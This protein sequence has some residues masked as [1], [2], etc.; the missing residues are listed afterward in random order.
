MNTTDR[1]EEYISAHIDPEDPLLYEMTR[2]AH[3]HLLHPRMLSGHLQGTLMKMMMRMINPRTV[4]EIGTYTG[5]STLSMA[6]GLT[7][8]D[9]RIHTVE[10]D[11][12]MQPGI[13]RFFRRSEHAHRITLHIGDVAD[14]IGRIEGNFDFVFMDGNKRNYTDYYD[15]VMPRLNA[16]GF[17]LADNVLWDGKVVE[18]VAPADGQTQGIV[19]FND[20]VAA[21]PRVEKVIL[22]IRDGLMLIRKK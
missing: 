12:E 15:L 7:R 3:V 17:I 2:F 20:M 1:L 11:D 8:P 5:Y 22:P 21:D 4:L 19:R 10:I 9:A 13:E 16:G 18:P 14:V 6:A